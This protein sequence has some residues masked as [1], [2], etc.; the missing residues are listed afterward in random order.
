[1]FKASE[2]VS[3]LKAMEGMPYWYG[4]CVYKCR[5]TLLSSKSNQYPSH[6]KSDRIP[7]YKLHISNKLVC[8]DCVGLIKGFFWTNGGEGVLE[9]IGTDKTFECKYASNGMPDVSATGLYEWCKKKGAKHGEIDTLPEVPGTPIFKEGHTG[10]YIGN[11]KVIEARGY[12]RGI[13]LSDISEVDWTH[14]AF[15]PSTI[16]DYEGKDG[17]EIVSKTYSLG[18]RVLSLKKPYMEGTDV[19]QLQTSLNSI[20]FDCGKADGIF[21]SKT[22]TAVR[23][24]QERVCITVDGKVGSETISAIKRYNPKASESSET[25]KSLLNQF[26]NDIANLDSYK[27]LKAAMEE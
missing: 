20:G 7:T 16:L 13:I 12:S 8:A 17:V 10:V 6:Y 19:K 11:N 15:L 26:L 1:M 21:G 14:W 25:I 24:F 27:K 22:D 18:D 9:S 5:D 3:F 4:T 2:F 23:N